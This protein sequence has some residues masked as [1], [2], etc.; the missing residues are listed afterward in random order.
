MNVCIENNI[1]VLKLIYSYLLVDQTVVEKWKESSLPTD[2]KTLI[3]M[4]KNIIKIKQS[5]PRT[6]TSQTAIINSVTE[7]IVFIIPHFK[8]ISFP[9][10]KYC[11]LCQII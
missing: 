3:G 1:H 6:S 4:G 9:R 7:G 5:L 8:Y 11:I 2:T 10:F